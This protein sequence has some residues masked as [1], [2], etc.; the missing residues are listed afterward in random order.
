MNC[1]KVENL[2]ENDEKCRF[3]PNKHTKKLWDKE[4]I[5]KFATVSDYLFHYLNQVCRRQWSWRIG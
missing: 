3:S 4:K 5:Y 2:T 1:R